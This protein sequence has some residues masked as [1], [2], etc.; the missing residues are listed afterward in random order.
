M[1]AARVTIDALPDSVP[2]LIFHF[3]VEG[4]INRL[5]RLMWYRLVKVCRR[6]RSV[7]FAYPIFLNL[8]LVCHPG[9]HVEHIG[10]WPALPISIMNYA[11]HL[12][13]EDY[14]FHI[15]IAHPNRVCEI[16]L[17]D[18]SSSQLQRLASAMQE[19]FL[20][21]RHLKLWFLP[22]RNPAPAPVLPE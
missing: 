5:Y 1:W 2:L 16:E 10:I 8:K 17:Y 21:L 7:V 18:M 13:P 3:G 19:Q 4:D 20:A 14:D 11:D 22:N 6:W 12:M 9:I 15:A